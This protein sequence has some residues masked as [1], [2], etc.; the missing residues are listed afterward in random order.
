MKA[1]WQYHIENI[2][3]NPATDQL[4]L[5]TTLNNFGKEGWELVNIQGNV[6]YFKRETPA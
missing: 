3:F 6:F 4:R 1:T 2:P 5:N